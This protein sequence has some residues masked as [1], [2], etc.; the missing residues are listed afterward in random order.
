MRD[1]ILKASAEHLSLK[2]R[3]RNTT[4]KQVALVFAKNRLAVCPQT[5]LV[6]Y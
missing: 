5:S 3:L 2:F 4:K 6:H 1:N